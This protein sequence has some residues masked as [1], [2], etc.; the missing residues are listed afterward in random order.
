MY[1]RRVSRW[2]ATRRT[3]SRCT[4][5]VCTVAYGNG[6]YKHTRLVWKHS[7]EE[8]RFV[9]QN[10]RNT[11]SDTS[12]RHG[13]IANTFSRRW[14]TRRRRGSSHHVRC[15]ELHLHTSLDMQAGLI[16]VRLVVASPIVV[17]RHV[18]TSGSWHSCGSSSERRG[19]SL[20]LNPRHTSTTRFPDEEPASNTTQDIQP[21]RAAHCAC[22]GLCLG[23]QR[24]HIYRC[25]A[26]CLYAMY[27]PEH[28]LHARGGL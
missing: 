14:K 18:S 4:S 13:H 20:K 2:Q 23:S 10:V 11:I 15:R 24:R 27:V 7:G 16:I 8:E 26:R 25:L 1:T 19:A 6:H 21:R 5:N 12:L 17:S 28:G 22:R 3:P 9:E